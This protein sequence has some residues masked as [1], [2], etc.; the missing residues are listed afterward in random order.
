M[1][2]KSKPLKEGQ[3]S[4]A[5]SKP[6]K[7]GTPP[8]RAGRVCVDYHQTLQLNQETFIRPMWRDSILALKKAGW[9][10]CIV[11]FV[12]PNNREERL[13]EIWGQLGEAN[14]TSEIE[15]VWTCKD[16][17]GPN[18]KTRL[19]QELGCKAIIDDAPEILAEALE[20]GLVVFPIT[21][22]RER[23][24]ALKKAGVT[25]YRDLPSAS[26]ALLCRM[27]DPKDL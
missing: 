13:Q 14:L 16:R 10:V 19:A 26:E 18:G 24:E 21:T 22:K 15:G 4:A 12:T 25:V 27:I 3:G 23:H 8:L 1:A 9:E 5:E 17:S 2:A 20:A 7:E 6:S 11:S